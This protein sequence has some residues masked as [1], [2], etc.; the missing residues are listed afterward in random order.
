MFFYDICILTY[1]LC[2]VVENNKTFYEYNNKHTLTNK[3]IFR[4]YNFEKI[5]SSIRYKKYFM[6]LSQKKESVFS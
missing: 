5:Y 1:N 4:K 6:Y 3:I 2:F